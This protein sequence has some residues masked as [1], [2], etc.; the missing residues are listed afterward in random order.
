MSLAVL[1]P[2][3]SRGCGRKILDNLE[4]LSTTTLSPQK[5]LLQVFLGID[6]GDEILDKSDKPAEKILQKYGIEVQSILFKPSNPAPICQ[7]WRELA[8]VA[9]DKPQC[10]YFILL[11]DDVTIHNP[12]WVEAIID[13]FKSLHQTK[14]TSLPFGFG[15]IAL[16]DTSAVGFPTFPIVHRLHLDI[17]GKEHIIPSDFINQDGDPYLFQLYKQWGGSSFLSGVTLQ[18]SIGGLQLLEEQ[19]IT[20]RYERVHIDWKFDILQKHTLI[21]ENWINSNSEDGSHNKRKIMIDV[22]TPSY[23]VDATFLERIVNLKVPSY[24]ETTFIIIV[25]NPKANIKWLREIEKEKQGSLRV[26]KNPTNVGASSSRNVGLKE[27]AAD[28]VVFLDDDVIPDDNLLVE[29]SKAITNHGDK[30]DGFAGLTVLPPDTKVFPNAVTLSDVTYFWDI[31]NKMETTPWS[32]TANMVVNR[33]NASNLFFD[34]RFIKTGGGEDIDYCLQLKKWPLLCVPTAKVVHPWW[35]NGERCYS[36]FY[37]WAIGDSHL[38]NKYPKLTY[39]SF[40]NVWEMTVFLLLLQPLLFGTLP[41]TLKYIAIVWIVDVTLDVLR[42]MVLKQRYQQHP[43]PQNIATRFLAS[44][45][46]NIV[47]N[48]CELGHLL[49]PIMRGNVTFITKRFEWFCGTL[50]GII[51]QEQ[52]R[53]FKR[54]VVFMLA[55]MVALYLGW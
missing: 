18:N 45:E 25:D 35:H 11:G 53:S 52:T 4:Q 29:Y 1:L 33:R 31:A 47:K 6:K 16:N 54:F 32:I 49:G 17:F 51:R 20:P 48:S 34:D 26:R 38:M 44:L 37:R 13:G 41:K 9:Y 22:I 40:P 24:C 19:Y 7:F 2:I 3:T 42:N 23:R 8:C 5:D 14:F 21:L 12:R 43:K 50:P 46:S 10:E 39:R 27:S 55:I 15:C 36:H 30:Y 28:W